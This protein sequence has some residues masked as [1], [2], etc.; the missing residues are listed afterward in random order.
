MSHFAAN[1]KKCVTAPRLI[2]NEHGR[3]RLL[4]RHSVVQAYLTVAPFIAQYP[5]Y[6]REMADHLLEAKLQHWD[7]ALRETASQALAGLVPTEPALFQ[8]YFVDAL[9]PLCLSPTL[10]V[11]PVSLVGLGLPLLE[12]LKLPLTCGTV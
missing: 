6:R 10:E 9:L 2:T 5:E 4:L 7:R 3:R 12:P 1:I 8:G 11:S